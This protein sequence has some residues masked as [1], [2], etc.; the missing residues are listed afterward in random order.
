MDQDLRLGTDSLAGEEIPGS[1]DSADSGPTG[2]PS[3]SLAPGMELRARALGQRGHWR[4]LMLVTGPGDVAGSHAHWRAGCDDPS[5]PSIAYSSQIYELA[6]ALGSDLTVLHETAA[7]ADTPADAR[8]RFHQMPPPKGSGI[9]FHL[10]E[11]GHALGTVARAVWT[12]SDLIILQRGAVHFWPLALARLFGCR[13]MVS[14]HNTL[15]PAHRR[16]S[17]RERLI[18]RLNGWFFR[19]TD[20][21]VAVS[22]AARRQAISVSGPDHNGALQ[23]VPQYQSALARA[24]RPRPP[25]RGLEQLLYL[26][27]IEEDKG[28][29]DL[30][31]AFAMIAPAQPDLRLRFVG[32]GSDLD[33]LRGAAEAMP[34]SIARRIEIPGPV[35]GAEVFEELS[36]SDLLV[37]PTT[38]RF[39]EGLAKTPVEA[40]I[41]GVPSLITS[42]V[43]VGELLG[44][45]A[46]TI[47]ADNVSAMAMALTRLGQEPTRLAAMAAATAPCRDRLFD[48]SQSLASR[49][50]VLMERTAERHPLPERETNAAVLG[51]ALRSGLA[52]VRRAFPRMLRSGD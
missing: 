30:L 52:L 8:I 39:A 25:A 18:N 43:P 16:Q 34:H 10:A 35:P 12:R 5:I 2:R 14:M 44:D 17:R 28:V 11:I 22:D 40:A 38:G 37:C 51:R 26:G 9:G 46:L 31:D 21:V 1:L 27:R 47:P 4:R 42:V 23:Q 49:L 3:T 6:E 32:T 33:R 48:R 36:R 45:A 19:R 15:W 13:I 41:M 29:F 24:W 7:P 50:L 20:G